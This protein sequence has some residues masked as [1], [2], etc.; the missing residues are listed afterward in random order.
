[1]A[2]P[3]IEAYIPDEDWDTDNSV[4][5]ENLYQSSYIGNTLLN[6]LGSYWYDHYEDMDNLHLL[7]GSVTALIGTEYQAILQQVLSSSIVDTPI[8]QIVPYQ[9][10]AFNIK[11]ARYVYTSPG[12]IERIEFVYPGL[13][14]IEFLSS[15]LLSSPVVMQNGEY[16]SVANG[17][18]SFYV[19][20]FNDAYIDANAYVYSTS[21]LS[22]DPIKVILLW[23]SDV[24]ME[25]TFLYDRYGRYLYSEQ[26]NSLAYKAILI[27]L[28]Y[29]FTTTKSVK[30]LEGI[31]NI[32]FNL[33][34]AKT[35]GEIVTGIVT[36]DQDGNEIAGLINFNA[37][38][39]AETQEDITSK[40]WFHKITTTHNVY[41]APIYAEMQ[42]AV[43][44]TLS[45]YQLLCR[46]HRAKDYISDPDWYN[47]ARFPF[48]LVTVLADYTV[49]NTPPE[50]SKYV[51]HRYNSEVQYGA[52]SLHTGEYAIYNG[53]NPFLETRSRRSGIEFEQLLYNLVD[54]VLKYNL[55][56]IQTELNYD[57]IEYYQKNRI[58]ES[59][60]AV[61]QGVP[62]YLYPVLETLYKFELIDQFQDT[63]E[64]MVISIALEEDHEVV[65]V[66][67]GAVYGGAEGFGNPAELAH[68]GGLTYGSGDPVPY[69]P[70]GGPNSVYYGGG[71]EVSTLALSHLMG[72]SFPV[73][74]IDGTPSSL[75]GM[76]YN[77]YTGAYFADGSVGFTDNLEDAEPLSVTINALLEDIVEEPI[78][79]LAMGVAME[80]EEYGTMGY[81][82]EVSYN[83]TVPLTYGSS[84]LNALVYDEALLWDGGVDFSGYSDRK[85]SVQFNAVEK[86]QG[87]NSVKYTYGSN[88][89]AGIQ[90]VD[91]LDV[92]WTHI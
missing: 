86:Y 4:D 71:P 72:D 36:I 49:L 82:G 21:D 3:F 67:T 51:P 75:L 55:L 64:D 8:T 62:T 45:N 30:N 9:L 90:V 40:G 48:E 58:E 61:T 29:F 91:S 52:S 23:A 47:D 80:F 35:P 18:L 39:R 5:L 68:D 65:V 42:V 54:T 76:E 92:V 46:V 12:I 56:Y 41:F 38:A 7:A 50:F 81:T 44:D 31:L 37:N 84:F 19:D 83:N 27:A 63:V 16:F 85:D 10:F 1:M 6:I 43:G 60:T 32:L 87:Y 89:P 22:A 66:G 78:D 28:Q 77:T 20:I 13:E 70:Y 33:P 25:D 34:F 24:C 57:N 17:V 59:Y 26:P 79:T 53:V 88:L 11:D 74:G 14:N 73:L 2:L 15:G 69:H